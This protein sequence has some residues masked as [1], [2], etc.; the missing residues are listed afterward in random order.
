M[1][2][3]QQKP[4]SQ[5]EVNAIIADWD[6]PVDFSGRLM[7]G[8]EL[9]HN[10]SLEMA[11]FRGAT[12]RG[13]TFAHCKFDNSHF[14]GADL[15]DTRFI[16]CKMEYCFFDGAQMEHAVFDRCALVGSTG[17]NGDTRTQSEVIFDDMMGMVRG[18]NMDLT[19]D[20][21]QFC[22]EICMSDEDNYNSM[23]HELHEE[24]SEIDKVYPGMG[25]EIFNSGFH[26]L[27]HELNG[28]ANFIAQ[29]CSVEGAHRYA[30]DGACSISNRLPDKETFVLPHSDVQQNII[31][32][33]IFLVQIKRIPGVD[34]GKL[35]DW[36]GLARDLSE[37][38]D[39][40]C[41]HAHYRQYL[42]E[43]GEAF[44]QIDQSYPGVAARIFNHEAGYLPG[45]LLPAAEWIS[46][47]GS[48]Q[49]AYE[50]ARNGLFLDSG[51]EE[52]GGMAM[53]M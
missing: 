9:S 5:A 39:G 36:L 3:E 33:R 41:D 26:F 12:L 23:L 52:F 2:K 30:V 51:P 45:E 14:E 4:I 47:G 50:M 49:E 31:A 19:G 21:R 32:E 53:R 40:V 6:S 10:R 48:A 25:A 43:F 1:E 27:P 22:W 37:V 35:H 28:A 8:I 7:V 11:D 20:W 34:F 15:G 42:R 16:R 44:D 24:F 46:C 13:C 18:V 29:G 17:L 38:D